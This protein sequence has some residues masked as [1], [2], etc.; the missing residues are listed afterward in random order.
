MQAMRLPE[1]GSPWLPALLALPLAA[2]IPGCRSPGP[3]ER[4]R[5]VL[6]AV[7]RAEYGRDPRSLPDLRRALRG[8]DPWLR[9][10][11]L[12]AIGRIGGPGSLETLAKALADPSPGVVA[13]AVFQLGLREGEADRPAAR[14]ALLPLTGK[15]E[16]LVRARAFEALGR[17][18]EA[19]GFASLAAGLED[20]AAT[21]RGAAALALHRL[22]SRLLARGALPADFDGN[23]AKVLSKAWTRERS[24]AAAW[25]LVYALAP[26]RRPETLPILLAGAHPRHGRAL[27]LFSLRGLAGLVRSKGRGLEAEAKA[28]IRKAFLETLGDPDPTLV[29]EAV[30]GLS[31]PSPQGRNRAPR[32]AAPPFGDGEVLRA[33]AGLLHHRNPHVAAAAALGIGHFS[34]MAREAR[35]YL[36]P[37]EA[38]KD[39]T[40]KGAA[41]Q[42]NARL[43]GD[44]VTGILRLHLGSKDWTVRAS[45]AGALVFLSPR[46][47][48]RLASELM[49]DGDRRVRLAVLAILPR[50]PADR[51]A[52]DLA[53]EALEVRDLGLREK[54]ASVL[55]KIGDEAALPGL[56][57]AFTTSP[58]PDF[59]DARREALEAMAKIA[60]KDEAVTAFLREALKDP[61][62]G[63]RRSA[64]RL[65][66]ERLDAE[67]LPALE[68]VEGP[69]L[70]PLPG[71]NYEPSFLD[72]KPRIELRTDKGRIL[73]ELDPAEAPAHCWNFYAF[74]RAGQ[75]D[76]RIFHRVVPGFV[77]QGGDSRGDG[78]GASAFLG[79]RLRDEI[80]NLPFTSWVLGMPKSAAPDSGGEQIFLTLV[81]TPHLDGRYTAFGRVVGGKEVLTRIEIGDRILEARIVSP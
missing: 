23:L 62:P 61:D 73:L 70:D 54:A 39:P 50:F 10:R 38:S 72:R 57:R 53:L 34:S 66:S 28:R 43:L 22:R 20:P 56:R 9:K 31:D 4:Q 78:Y 36:A 51:E 37:I 13:E 5:E 55:A 17:L 26:L 15:G 11:I 47:A 1:C 16:A 19:S 33:L 65:L 45:V 75:Y 68:I 49:A 60:P 46:A 7:L 8:A 77:V 80:N 25:R 44:V 79:G 71:R 32:T 48:L 27:R 21:V 58:G 29:R 63:V 81:P 14:G 2:S 30:L 64:H 74:V 40:L 59:A 35:G 42:A 18:A 12:R 76:G 52:Q 67:A 6:A 41:L 69:R 24:E 3:A